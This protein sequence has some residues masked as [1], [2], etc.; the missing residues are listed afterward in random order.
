MMSFKLNLSSKSVRELTQQ[1]EKARQRGDLNEATRVSALLSFSSGYFIDEVSEI[2]QVAVSTLY[3]WV[4]QYLAKGLTGLL[5][6]KRPGRPPKLTKNQRKKLA[7][8]IEQ[9]PEACGFES[10]CWV[11]PMIQEL[12]LEKFGVFYSV[13]YLSQLLRTLGFSYQKAKFVAANQDKEQREAWLQDTWPK[14]LKKAKK[15]NAYIL[16]G[17]ESSFPQWGTLSYT[18]ARIGKQPVVKTSGNRKSYK[19]LGAIDYFTGKFFAKGHLGK[20]NADSYI[21]Y[22]KEILSQTR[23]H[24]FLIQDGAPYHKGSKMQKF[25]KENKHRLTVYTLPAYSP[26]YNPIEML[27]KK[28]KRLG[29]HLKYFPTFDSLVDRV[30]KML[31]EFSCAADEV[32]ALFGLYTK[33]TA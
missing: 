33:K 29:T 25:L 27:W 10:A 32:L 1:L 16:F 11:T 22:L 21:Q 31:I 2:L 13:N 17:D 6:K 8:W 19:V 5:S 28:I 14:I 4:R 30:E 7:C 24:I 20:L 3:Q 12:I 18:W 23:K 15:M 9:G 26:D